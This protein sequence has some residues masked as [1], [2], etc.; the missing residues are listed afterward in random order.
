MGPYDAPSCTVMHQVVFISSILTSELHRVPPSCFLLL[1]LVFICTM[2]NR[3]APRCTKMHQSPSSWLFFFYINFWIAPSCTQCFL[4]LYIL[5]ICTVMHRAPPS[6]TQLYLHHDALTC[7]VMLRVAPWCTELASFF[8]YYLLNCTEYQ[9]LILIALFSSHLH[10]VPLSKLYFIYINFLIAHSNTELLF[11]ASFT[12]YMHC[13]A[14]RCTVMH[15]VAL[16]CTKLS[17]FLL[18]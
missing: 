17:L 18:Y 14:L 5:L 6:C 7:T 10:W 12:S 1:Y 16:W 3:N 11:F 15:L 4:L 13:D 8:L 2:I 9:K